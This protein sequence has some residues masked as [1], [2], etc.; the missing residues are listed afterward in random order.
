MVK[1]SQIQ[2]WSGLE[3]F[4]IISGLFLILKILQK[5]ISILMNL[6]VYLEQ[7]MKINYVTC[8]HEVNS[9]DARMLRFTICSLRKECFHNMVESHI[10]NSLL[11]NILMYFIGSSY[12]KVSHFYILHN[13]TRTLCLL[14]LKYWIYLRRKNYRLWHY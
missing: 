12:V 4:K 2:L 13:A 7:S 10:T 1:V 3:I 14:S 11:M 8:M 5:V 6:Y 9:Y